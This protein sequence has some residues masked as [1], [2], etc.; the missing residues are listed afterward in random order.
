[1]GKQTKRP[2]KAAGK[3]PFPPKRHSPASVGQSYDLK[4]LREQLKP[5]RLYW[6]TRLSSTNSH[7][8]IL[9]RRKQLYAPAVILTGHQAK[10]RGRGSNSWW[11]GKGSM[12]ATFVL[13]IED[14]LQ[15]HQIPLIAGLATR[16]AVAELSGLHD[17]GLKWPNDLLHD[18]KKLAGLL[19]ERIDQVDLIGIGLNVNVT[20]SVVPKSLRDR[21]TSLRT[22]TGQVISLSDVVVAIA[23][24]LRLMLSR[25][26][27]PS[28]GPLLKEY[29]R[30]HMLVGR[31][32]RVISQPGEAPLI[33]KVTG[34]DSVGR[35]LVRSAGK[36]HA[37][38]AG[39]IEILKSP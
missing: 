2:V 29:D 18:G 38:I 3:K 27:Q 6:F 30:H 25:N 14:H 34:L 23:W 10:G 19:C 17:I 37:V 5:F 12:T 33:G 7:A 22:I 16:N 9:R 28:F 36:S 26:D 4:V 39:S 8:M 15:P 35:L 20:T 24:N 11:S 21:V 32:V 31:S 1:M 13:P